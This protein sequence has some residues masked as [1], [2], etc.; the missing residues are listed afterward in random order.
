MQ[1]KILVLGGGFA[2]NAYHAGV[3]KALEDNNIKFDCIAASSMASIAAALYAAGKSP[4][5]IMMCILDIKRSDIFS[6]MEFI[7]AGKDISTGK[8]LMD[9]IK[10]HL[11]VS[12][13]SK[14]IIPLTLTALDLKTKKEVILDNG[15]LPKA[16]NSAIAFGPVFKEVEHKGKLLIDAGFINP[17]PIDLADRDQLIIGAKITEKHK[18]IKR[19]N[20]LSMYKATITIHCN[21]FY[22]LKVD[23]NPPDVLID[24]ESETY[25]DWMFNRK[26]LIS[27]YKEGEKRALSMIEKIKAE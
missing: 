1:K 12:D 20:L 7:S 27:L 8:K 22:N 25:T 21:S 2:S 4:R 19:L 16:L 24:S 17:L 14:L 9:K 10:K 18:P 15:N 5:D 13:F 11:Q 23:A 26:K 6:I 3:L